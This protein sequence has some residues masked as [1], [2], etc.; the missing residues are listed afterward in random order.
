MLRLGSY[1]ILLRP[2][3]WLYGLGVRIRSFLFDQ[4]ILPSRQYSVPIICVGNITVGGTGKT[5][6]VEYILSRLVPHYRVAVLSRGYGRRSHGLIV[7]SEHSTAR[8]IGDEPK[9][10]LDKYPT[11]TLVVDGNRRRAMN[12]LLDLPLEQRPQVVVMDDGLQHRYIDPSC[13]ILLI[14]ST[15]SI[16]ED[17]LLPEGTLRE[18]ASARYR[19]DII[20]VTKCLEEFTPIHQRL[21]ERTLG[22]YP[23]QKL[24]F[25]RIKYRQPTRVAQSLSV[26]PEAVSKR[27]TIPTGAPILVV[28]GVANPTPFVAHLRERYAVIREKH[29]DDHHN[30]TS[31]DINE[32]NAL[33]KRLR[34]E[35]AQ[36][37]YCVCTEKDAVRLRE[38]ETHICP[39]L[40]VRLYYLP[41]EI[42]VIGQGD[43]LNKRIDLAARSII[44]Q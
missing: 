32:L 18:H 25:S 33:F 10:I 9:Q 3:A 14:D 17:R 30:F 13:R 5:P 7:A 19:A 4:G 26:D 11:I 6:H 2:L 42:E 41:I 12:Y 43:E 1:Q 39:E 34:Q 35:H 44:R 36:E 8:E 40:L 37:V 38:V 24:F 15:R 28:S 27:E 29:F 23:H 31:E 22:L 16:L 20:I 21:M